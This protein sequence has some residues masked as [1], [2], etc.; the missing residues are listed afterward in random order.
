MELT[1]FDFIIIISYYYYCYA[2]DKSSMQVLEHQV[3]FFSP[4]F[5][6]KDISQAWEAEAGEL[7][8]QDQPRQS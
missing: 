5:I 7:Q 6:I 2:R 3:T 8:V 1:V 4:T